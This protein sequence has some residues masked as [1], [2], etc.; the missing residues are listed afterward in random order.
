MGLKVEQNIYETKTV[1]YEEYLHIQARVWER[2]L[3][4]LSLLA[5]NRK[6]LGSERLYKQHEY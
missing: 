4:G 3:G 5:V 6:D 1:G 2:G